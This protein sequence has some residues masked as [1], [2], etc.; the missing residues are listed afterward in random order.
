[1]QW[2][3][4]SMKKPLRQWQRKEPGVFLHV[5]EGW[6]TFRWV[7]PLSHSSWSTHVMLSGN[8]LVLFR[9]WQDRTSTDFPED[10][11][12]PSLQRNSAVLKKS[13]PVSPQDMLGWPVTAPFLSPGNGQKAMQWQDTI[14]TQDS[15]YR[16]SIGAVQSQEHA[17]GA[18]LNP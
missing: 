8:C 3:C 6:Q 17:I 12:K 11:L 10:S 18:L 9:T 16:M 5:A 13:A 2:P 7:D 4:S 14:Q 1:M 15:S